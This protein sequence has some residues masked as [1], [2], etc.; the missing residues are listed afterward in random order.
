MGRVALAAA[1]DHAVNGTAA[2]QAPS[3]AG[4]SASTRNAHWATPAVESPNAWS[5]GADHLAVRANS[6]RLRI[7]LLRQFAYV[8]IDLAMVMASGAILDL[9]FA[10][11]HILAVWV[12][13]VAQL[14]AKSSTLSPSFLLLYAALIVLACKSQ[15]LYRTPK[16]L[17]ATEETFIVAKAVGLATALLVLFIFT[18]DDREISRAAVACAG[19]LNIFTLA[20]WRYAKRRYV[21]HRALQDASACRVLI[22]GN[23]KSAQAFSSWLTANR[24]LG[25]SVRGLLQT[26]QAEAS[27]GHVSS[28]QT[29]S[30]CVIGSVEDLRRIALEEFIDQLF[31][32]LPADREIVKQVFLEAQRLRLD[33]NVV[34][35]IYDGL[36]WHAPVHSIGGFPVLELHGQPIPAFGLA[37][38]RAVDFALGS[39]LFV[40]AAPILAIAALAISCDSAGPIF[41]AAQ[42]MG[43]KGKKFR[44]YKLR[45]M[46]HDADD[47]KPD[48]RNT[49]NQ[50]NGPFFKIEND[51]R[52][53]RVGSWLRRFSIDELPQLMNVIRGDMS[54]VG[55]RPH[56]LDD[57]ERYGAEDLRRLDVKP[58]LTGLW[59]VAARRDPSFETNMHCDLQYIENW[60]LYLDVKILLQT[61]P[62]V[63][64]GEGN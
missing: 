31:I 62:A 33:L 4:S 49:A 10:R 2:R 21:L 27:D 63:L 24:H 55:P 22:I 14:L 17:T 18:S 32:A 48:L 29:D 45:T 50:R 3:S 46:V 64:R 40:F 15:H 9:T 59:Q 42:R 39:L 35:D 56:P 26:S 8:A 12:P 47:R 57:V 37:T 44:C 43:K 25:Y 20:G 51:P 38:K 6:G 28:S 7:G 34:P 5:S 30:S 41:Y 19:A 58:G 16:E 60:S 23:G 36:G 53:T 11:L 13:N 1:Q 54:L 52:I 61:V